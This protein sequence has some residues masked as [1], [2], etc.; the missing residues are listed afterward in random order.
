MKHPVISFQLNHLEKNWKI[1]SPPSPHTQMYT[2]LWSS[3]L[4]YL[5]NWKR[6]NKYSLI[7]FLETKYKCR[8]SQRVH[9]TPMSTSERLGWHI[10]RLTKSPLRVAINGYIAYHWK[11]LSNLGH[12]PEW[13]SSTTRNLTSWATF[14]SQCWN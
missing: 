10:L 4:F 13:A 5:F 11:N 12:E 3:L 6:N 7:F 14:N 1:K 2:T 9:T 8:R